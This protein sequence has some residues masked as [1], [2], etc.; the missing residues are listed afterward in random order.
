MASHYETLGV[1][2]DASGEEIKKAY[3]KLAR[4]LHPDVNTGPEAADQ[5]KAVSHAYEVLSDAEKRRNYDATGNENGNG[6]QGGFGGG[7][8]FGGFGDIF[9]QFFGGSGGS[10]GPRSRTEPGRDAL[11]RIQI[12]LEDTVKGT[13]YPLELRT[14]VICPLCEGSCCEPGSH[15][16]TCDVCRG[17]GHVQRPVRSIL[18]QMMTLA[19]CPACQG[20][21]TTLPKPCPECQGAGRVADQLEKQLKIPAG[22]SSGTRIHLAGGGEAGPGGGPQGDLYVEIDVERHPVFEREGNDLKA[23]LT[24]PLTAAALGTDVTLETFDGEQ[25]VSIKPGSESGD[26][27]RLEDLGVPRLRGNGRGDLVVEVRVATPRNLD[28][29]QRE[30]LEKLAELRGE[31]FT[32]GKFEQRGLM[33]RLRDKLRG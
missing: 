9:D 7:G 5:F 31:T 2:A 22:V 33:S 15:P 12:S 32:E 8:G 29:A 23:V 13:V 1:S 3:R 25:T 24:V 27:V 30:L 28:D 17:A 16:A 20:Y 4:K 6:A 19:E 10:A 21:G 14:A 11:V 18:G 26:A